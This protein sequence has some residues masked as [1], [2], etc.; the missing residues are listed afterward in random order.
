PAQSLVADRYRI[1]RELGRGE[2]APVYP[3]G[4]VKHV[5]HVALNVRGAE[6]GAAYGA[7]RF[8]REIGIVARLAHPHV[9]PLIDSG[10]A[11]G[12]QLF[13]VSAY[14]PGGS[15]RD[16]LRRDGRLALDDALAVAHDVAEALDYAHRQGV[17]H[18]DV[19]PENIL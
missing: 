7:E 17:V 13:F 18:R 8:L 11:G 4:D 14:L 3:A 12:G 1:E 9:V 2:E 5:R 15:L 19:K 16:R 6:L 10:D